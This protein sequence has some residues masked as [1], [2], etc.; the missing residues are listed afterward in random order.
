M[1]PILSLRSK[2]FALAVAVIVSTSAS[3]QFDLEQDRFMRSNSVQVIKLKKNG[4]EYGHAVFL[5]RGESNNRVK[6]KYFAK[7]AYS[8]YQQWKQNKDIVLVS[9]GAYSTSWNSDATP[10]G[11]CVDNGEIVN[12]NIENSMDGLVIVEAVGGVR[13]SD[14]DKK[15]LYLQSIGKQIS[16][17][18]DKFLLMNWGRDENATIFQTHLLAY[19]DGLRINPSRSSQNTATRRLLVLGFFDNKLFHAVFHITKDQTLYQATKDVMETMNNIGIK[20]VSILN[21]D[22]GGKD[23]LEVFDDSRSK[24][25]YI[26]GKEKVEIATNLL[27]YYYE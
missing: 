25:P 27:I 10:V 26:M 24:I 16:P 5:L 15:D 8:A 9:S 12:R 7:N 6:A 18:D 3:A 2:L 1:N 14:I 11:L 23:I 21:L 22:T 17:R 20:V 13:V 4:T 19:T